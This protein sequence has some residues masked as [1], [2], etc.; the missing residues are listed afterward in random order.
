MARQQ[1]TTLPYPGDGVCPS[2]HQFLAAYRASYRRWTSLITSVTC[3]SSVPS[4]VD[5]L[6]YILEQIP[7]FRAQ[8]SRPFMI[9]D[10]PYPQVKMAFEWVTTTDSTCE[11]PVKRIYQYQKLA[12]SQSATYSSI[13]SPEAYPY[14]PGIKAKRNGYLSYLIL[15]W[16]YILCSRWVETL[17]DSGE[18]T[19]M[20]QSGEINDN[21]FW[22]VVAMRPWQA[23]IVRGGKT[24][25][26]PWSL[27]NSGVVSSYVFA[28]LSLPS[29]PHN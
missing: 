28:L 18:D 26:A 25:Y 15:G 3:N 20:R 24:F 11:R 4:I 2:S 6:L 8:Y 23:G 19:F 1:Q 13:S 16:A 14:W 22:E 9:L 10:E 5:S 17:K 12:R 27:T 29:S 7:A 21:N